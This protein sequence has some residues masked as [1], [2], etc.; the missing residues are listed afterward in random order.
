MIMQSCEL[1]ILMPCLNEEETIGICIEKAMHFLQ[2]N[3]VS[4]EVLIADNGSTDGSKSIARDLGA[5]VVE[6]E[7][8][9]YGS[10]LLGGIGAAHGTYIIMG[11][12]DDSY[13]FL[14]LMP[15]LEKLREGY[16]LVMGNRF[17]GGIEKGAMPFLH[18]YLGN[19]VLSFIGKLF[20]DIPVNDFHCGLRGFN[21][22]SMMEIG[23]NTQGMEFASEMVVKSALN[24]LKITEVPTT[25]SPDGRSRPPHLNTWRDGWRHLRF[26]LIYSPQWLFFYPGIVFM[27]LGTVFSVL[28]I[29]EPLYLD[30]VRLDIHTLLYSAG[31]VF[32]GFQLIS[33]Y[34]LSRVYAT[35]S[36]LLPSNGLSRAID[37]IFTL[38]RSIAVGLILIL[39]GLGL[40]GY[41]YL[42]W[43]SVEYG[44][45]A[46]SNTFRIV[47]PGL[48]LL[49][50][51]IQFI[52]TGFFK[53]I[54][55]LKTVKTG[56][57]ETSVPQMAASTP[58][59]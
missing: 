31:S 17:K 20:F 33:F 21:R 54:L 34:V 2:T 10:A 41:S 12:S 38:E 36:E 13:D 50:L 49:I 35:Q 14:N 23:L 55:E 42:I 7:E 25:L 26:L 4:G 37:Q 28:L 44:D 58:L 27:L 51:G 57:R 43:Q 45:L 24:N 39:S 22:E 11:D 19:P 1:T 15:H 56:G 46:A 47:I 9:G 29:Q 18:R 48:M 59:S 53:S 8:K 6:V 5:R 52:F 32:I 3:G 40:S 16:D 30:E